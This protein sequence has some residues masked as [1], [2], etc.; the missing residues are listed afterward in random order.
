MCFESLVY[1]LMSWEHHFVCTEQV[2]VYTGCCIPSLAN[3]H[4]CIYIVHVINV[5]MCLTFLCLYLFVGKRSRQDMLFDGLYQQCTD[6][7]RRNLLLLPIIYIYLILQCWS[8]SKDYTFWFC[9]L[10]MYMCHATLSDLL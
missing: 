10:N 6:K 2:A 4:P 7:R 1:S 5:Y 8:M 3:T 9:R